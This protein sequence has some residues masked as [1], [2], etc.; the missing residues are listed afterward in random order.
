MPFFRYSSSWARYLSPPLR[1]EVTARSEEGDHQRRA[2]RYQ[3][4]V[5][6]AGAQDAVYAEIDPDRPFDLAPE[7]TELICDH[8]RDRNGDA[9]K[10][11]VQRKS[12]REFVL[13]VQWQSSSISSLL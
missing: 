11:D 5:A 7:L 8:N 13:F 2:Q 4:K 6:P 1:A 9:H 3:D 10:H 12:A